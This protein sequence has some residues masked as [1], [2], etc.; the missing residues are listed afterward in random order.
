[1]PRRADPL[2]SLRPQDESVLF[3]AMNSRFIARAVGVGAL[4]GALLGRPLAHA[5]FLHMPRVELED[6]YGRQHTL[7]SEFRAANIVLLADQAGSAQLDGWIRALC[8][9]YGERVPLLG[10]ARLR[11][12]PSVARPL[13]RALF[14]RH[15]PHP[16]LLDWSGEVVEQLAFAPGR[17]NVLLVDAA[18]HVTRRWEGAASAETLDA[19]FRA[20]DALLNGSAPPPARAVPPPVPPE[21]ASSK[22]PPAL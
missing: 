11:G 7:G 18:G 5:T 9:R 21:P 12:V 19:C 14:R 2:A 8:G 15:V 20:I 17:A 22:A 3:G 6:Q 16:V 1:M 13:V 4:A 10:V